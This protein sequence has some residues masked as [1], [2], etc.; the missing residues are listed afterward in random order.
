MWLWMVALPVS[1]ICVLAFAC[2]NTADADAANDADVDQDSDQTQ[3]ADPADGGGNGQSQDSDQNADIDEDADADADADQDARRDLRPLLSW[4]VGTAVGSVVSVAAYLWVFE[5]SGC[6]GRGDFACMLNENQGVLTFVALI[7]AVAGLC[8]AAWYR[9]RDARSARRSARERAKNA[10][11]EALEE[12][13]HNLIH[14][15]EAYDREKRVLRSVP[16]LSAADTSY[17]CDQQF[18][19]R[20]DRRIIRAAQNMGRNLEGVERSSN[21]DLGKAE[22]WLD[23]L[24]TNSLRLFLYAGKYAPKVAASFFEQPGYE[25]LRELAALKSWRAYF[26]SSEVREY[27]P[28]SEDTPV[29]CWFDDD[30]LLGRTVYAEY[31][32]FSAMKHPA[33]GL[34]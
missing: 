29:V 12:A 14:V 34:D 13:S 15:A 30:A 1:L 10:L 8:V 22:R 32:E 25:H 23:P 18:R 20:F 7:L 6:D 21:D 3:H 11:H 31:T 27:P 2:V 9:E 5:G 33:H 26:R 19:L 24:V 17:L 16:Q 28:D 4:I